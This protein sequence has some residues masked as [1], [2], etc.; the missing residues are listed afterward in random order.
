MVRAIPRQVP[1]EQE[2]EAVVD[3]PTV[4]LGIAP[5]CA[6]GSLESGSSINLNVH[7]CGFD[8]SSP[9]SAQAHSVMTPG[10]DSP[11]VLG[12]LR[13]QAATEVQEQK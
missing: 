12:P 13:P 9:K 10:P 2:P 8:R 4:A 1:I 6:I 11:T 7:A 3:I 5:R